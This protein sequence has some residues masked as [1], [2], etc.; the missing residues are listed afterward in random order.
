M[1][2]TCSNAG[3]SR[4]GTNNNPEETGEEPLASPLTRARPL[5]AEP[6]LRIQWGAGAKLAVFSKE[7][8]M[9]SRVPAL[10]Q[11]PVRGIF[12]RPRK[13]VSTG[14]AGVGDLARFIVPPAPVLGSMGRAP[15]PVHGAWAATAAAGAAA[16]A[17]AVAV[18]NS[19]MHARSQAGHEGERGKD[20]GQQHEYPAVPDAAAARENDGAGWDD[21]EAGRGG[22]GRE[23]LRVVPRKGKMLSVPVAAGG[24]GKSGDALASRGGGEEVLDVAGGEDGGYARSDAAHAPPPDARRGEAEGAEAQRKGERAE[25]P[26][27]AGSSSEQGTDMGAASAM[28]GSVGGEGMAEEADRGGGDVDAQDVKGVGSGGR[29]SKDVGWESCVHVDA[30]PRDSIGR[31]SDATRESV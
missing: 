4:G 31:P 6:K 28:E 19:S 18:A 7:S 12:R 10:T 30:D 26:G 15:A 13:T 27:G 9:E 5:T 1:T 8:S 17:A 24:A 2:N 29:G 21:K 22:G 16:A 23:K 25:P 3:L 20:I 14:S 11:K